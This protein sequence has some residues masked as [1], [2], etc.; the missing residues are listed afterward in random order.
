MLHLLIQVPGLFRYQFHWRPSLSLKEPE[1]QKVLRLMGPRVL[2][3]LFIQLIFVVQDNL[4]S[5]LATGSVT[6]LTY[7]WWI[8]RYLADAD[9]YSHRDGDFA[10]PGGDFQQRQHV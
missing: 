8:I 1:T 2:S 5:R 10:H 9:R 6:A 4:A 3:M 7:G